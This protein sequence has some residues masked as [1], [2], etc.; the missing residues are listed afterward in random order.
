MG[1]FGSLFGSDQKDAAKDAGRAQTKYFEKN[2]EAANKVTD[3][4]IGDLD[5][6]LAAALGALDTGQQTATGALSANLD[7]Y[8]NAG[9]GALETLMAAFGLGGPQGNAN[10]LSQFQTGPGY[11][12]AM[13]QG[14][15][16][17]DRSAAARGGLYSGAQGKA[18]TGFGQ[19]L[20]NQEWGNW[21]S[22]LSGVAGSG[23][24]AATNIA[25]GTG[26]ILSNFAQNKAN[27]L[28][29]TG[30]NKGNLRLETLKSITQA[31]Q[32]IGSAKAGSELGEAQ[33]EQ[34]GMGNLLSILS[35]VA[36][37]ALGAF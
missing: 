17:L 5:A 26:N 35:S 2:I 18:L 7:P 15:Q 25:Q 4:G 10:A 29:G 24:N 1:L 11:G 33:A 16:A 21:L 31:N 37:R 14:V 23:Q 22:Q 28:L 8:A 34:A 32:G 13:D 12:F 30:E 20:A 9:R 3:A 6:A 19:G 27:A 36:T